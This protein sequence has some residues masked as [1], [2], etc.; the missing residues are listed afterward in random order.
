MVKIK[1]GLTV[2]RIGRLALGW[3]YVTTWKLLN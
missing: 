1:V 2:R 3:Y